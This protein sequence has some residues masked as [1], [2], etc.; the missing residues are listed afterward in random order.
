MVSEMLSRSGGSFLVENR[1]GGFA[2]RC[3]LLN[4]AK[5]YYS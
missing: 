4:P 1:E 5:D 3:Q 2:L